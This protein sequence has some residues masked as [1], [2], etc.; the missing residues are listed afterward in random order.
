M[1]HR[2]IIVHC[3]GKKQILIKICNYAY[4]YS[5]TRDKKRAYCINTHSYTP[6]NAIFDVYCLD[7]VKN[8]IMLETHI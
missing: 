1:I 5:L 8:N 3:L 2:G 7:E 4:Y 6:M